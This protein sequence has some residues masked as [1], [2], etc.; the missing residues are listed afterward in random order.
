MSDSF[1][2]SLRPIREKRD[3]PDSL[4]REIAQINAQWGS[5]RELSEA[6]L[7]EKIEED[8]HK[9]HWEEDDEDD[10]ESTDLETSEQL[11]QLYKRRAE[12]IQFAL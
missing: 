7:R 3:R 11:D 10:K 6:K 9:D 2:V 12:I 5:F 1:T 4:P 8:K